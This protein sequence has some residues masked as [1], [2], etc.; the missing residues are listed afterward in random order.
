MLHLILGRSGCWAKAW[1]SHFLQSLW[2]K[3]NAAGKDWLGGDSE[4]RPERDPPGLGAEACVV[5]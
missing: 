2:W 5:G 1:D 3:G 4:S